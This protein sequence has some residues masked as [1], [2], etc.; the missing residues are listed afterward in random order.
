MEQIIRCPCCGKEFNIQIKDNGEIAIV[1]FD[2]EQSL[3]EIQKFL[4]ENNIELGIMKGGE[5]G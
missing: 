3:E 2:I 1:F 4:S 5:I